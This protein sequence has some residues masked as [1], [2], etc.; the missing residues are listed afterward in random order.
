MLVWPTQCGHCAM[1]VSPAFYVSMLTD[2]FPLL[3]HFAFSSALLPLYLLPMS[4][5]VV[6]IRG[7]YCYGLD[8]VI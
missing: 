6:C 5:L 1:V 7:L 4:L 2:L 3:S 8:A